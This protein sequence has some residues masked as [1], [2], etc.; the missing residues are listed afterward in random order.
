MLLAN[1]MVNHFRITGCDVGQIESI[2]W[3]PSVPSSVI[4]RVSKVEMVDGF[5]AS[6]NIRIIDTQLTINANGGVII[7]KYKSGSSK[8]MPVQLCPVRLP[9]TYIANRG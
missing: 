2:L 6:F 1:N 8:S 5:T 7:V 9:D 3:F 4:H